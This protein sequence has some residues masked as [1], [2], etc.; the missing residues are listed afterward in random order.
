MFLNGPPQLSRVVFAERHHDFGRAIAEEVCFL[1]AVDVGIMMNL[2]SGIEWKEDVSGKVR[3][4]EDK[5]PRE[6]WW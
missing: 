2:A 4:M 6:F 3:K 5:L 1:D